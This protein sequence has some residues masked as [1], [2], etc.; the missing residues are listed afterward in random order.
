VHTRSNLRSGG[1]DY[2]VDKRRQGSLSPLLEAAY[3]NTKEGERGGG[4]DNE[5]KKVMIDYCVAGTMLKF[6]YEITHYF[7]NF[8][9]GG[10]Y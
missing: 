3:L 2:G 7:R 9:Y 10:Y 4:G 1:E 6:L 5:K 8:L